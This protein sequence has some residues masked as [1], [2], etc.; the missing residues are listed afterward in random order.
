MATRPL[1]RPAWSMTGREA[2]ALTA[3]VLGAILLAGQAVVH[4]QQYFSLYHEVRWI[5]PLFLLDGV[6]SAVVIAGLALRRWRPLAALAGV[7]IAVGALGG[8]AVSYGRGLFG[9]QEA[10][11]DT[12]I[13]LAV[14]CEVGAAF[15]LAA[16]PALGLAFATRRERQPAQPR[17]VARTASPPQPSTAS[18]VRS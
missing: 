5:G 15:F 6:A 12:P 14:V 1:V 16:G 13:E 18:S 11:F 3:Y 9:W 10:G 2:A 4:V 17:P 8:L 7:A